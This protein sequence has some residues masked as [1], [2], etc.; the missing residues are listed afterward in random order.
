[1]SSIFA[2]LMQCYLHCKSAYENEFPLF[3]VLPVC[4]SMSGMSHL[5]LKIAD[6]EDILC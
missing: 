5:L 6:L 2:V 4:L 1:M 3:F